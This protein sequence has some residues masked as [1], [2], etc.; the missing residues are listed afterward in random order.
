MAAPLAGVLF[1]EDFDEPAE[2]SHPAEPEVIAPVFS[3]EDMQTARDLARAEGIAAGLAQA[4]AEIAAEVRTSLQAME[5]QMTEAEAAAQAVAEVSGLELSRCILAALR[6]ALPALCERH[7]E[8]ELRG[9]LALVAPALRAQPQ[10]VARVAPGCMAAVTAHLAALELSARVEV[11]GDAALRPGD[12]RLTWKDGQA[13]RE[14]TVIL[15]QIDAAL[16]GLGMAAVQHREE[17]ANA[18]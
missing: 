15:A 14:A 4:Q 8:G 11:V 12:A 7:G 1:A 10:A 6:A 17:P 2:A 3:L 18:V 5:R 13:R 9:V 16:G